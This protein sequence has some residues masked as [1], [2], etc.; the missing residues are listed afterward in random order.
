MYDTDVHCTMF[1]FD[2]S[3]NWK[4]Y[5]LHSSQP[6][7]TLCDELNHYQAYNWCIFAWLLSFICERFLSKS[8]T[9]N[10]YL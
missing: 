2:I 6:R 9:T 4:F 5:N 10:L 3:V 7:T 1:L 8:I